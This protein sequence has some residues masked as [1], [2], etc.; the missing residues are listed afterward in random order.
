[1]V[2]QLERLDGLGPPAAWL[3]AIRAQIEDA[4]AAVA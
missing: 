3:E 1:M 2:E 4:Y